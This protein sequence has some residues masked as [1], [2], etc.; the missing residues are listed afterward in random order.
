MSPTTHF[1]IRKVHE[2]MC[3][4]WYRHACD[5][6]DDN[7]PNENPFNLPSTPNVSTTFLHIATDNQINESD[8]TDTSHNMNSS[9]QNP[10][11]LPVVW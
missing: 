8:W 5:M 7:Q 11:V 3:G 4:L 2:C 1:C 10:E 9:A 6:A